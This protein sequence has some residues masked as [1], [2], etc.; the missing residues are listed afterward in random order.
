MNANGSWSFDLKDQLDHVDDARTRE[1][2]DLRTNAAGTTSVSSIDFSSV[3]VGTDSDGD[4]VTAAGGSFTITVQ[5]DIPVPNAQ[6]TPI[7]GGVEEDGMSL[8]TGDLSEGAKQAGDTNADDETAGTNGS[9]KDLG[10]LFTSGA[11]EDLTI[12]LKST[13]AACR[14]CSRRARRYTTASTLRAR[15]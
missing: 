3:I 4:S 13:S 6:A 2:F 11:D 8:S 12:S 15:F 9:A 10:N 7:T 1:N 5:D 14:R